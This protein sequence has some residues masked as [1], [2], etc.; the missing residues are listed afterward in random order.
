MKIHR[1][2]HIFEA[3]M[4]GKAYGSDAVSDI[5]YVSAD[6]RLFSPLIP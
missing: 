1:L 2:D 4:L 6:W 3:E 5:S